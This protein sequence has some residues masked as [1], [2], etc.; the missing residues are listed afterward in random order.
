MPRSE[1]RAY[2]IPFYFL[3]LS[4]FILLKLLFFEN[5]YLFIVKVIF[6]VCLFLSLSKV[7]PY[8]DTAKNLDK[9]RKKMLEMY[10]NR[11]FKEVLFYDNTDELN[12]INISYRTFEILTLNPYSFT[13]IILANYYNFDKVY[14][15]PKGDKLLIIEM[16]EIT[17]FNDIIVLFDG[18]SNN[19]IKSQK[20]KEIFIALPDK[21][22]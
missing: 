12:K 6:L 9:E 5:N 14:S 20:D 17:D 19:L 22:N 21:R 15:I 8:L 1:P 16:E 10:K 3:I 2:L 11:N 18:E 7:L 4:I 13:N